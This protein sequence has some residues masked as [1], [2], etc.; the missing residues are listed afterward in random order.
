MATFA[1]SGR[2]RGGEA[3]S[4]ERIGDTM[5]TVVGGAAPRADPGHAHPAGRGQEPQA[6][7]V[8]SLKPRSVPAKNLAVFTRQF[9]VMIDAGL[10]LVQCLDILGNQEEHPYFAQVILADAGRRRRRH[11]ARR[12]DEEAPE[13][14]RRAVLQHDR[15]RRSGRHSRHH[16]EAAGRLHREGRQAE[17]PGAVGDDLSDRRHR[18]RRRRD[19][20]D[21][22]E[23]HPDLRAACSPASA[24]RCRCPPA[25]SSRSATT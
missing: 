18:H 13:G 11:V 23:G 2:T 7:A 6:N 15:R 10:P 16:S 24:P 12:R 25:S 14:V 4:G 20:R 3:V 1:F 19:R 17:E 5:D 9:S 22:V 21:L 8:K